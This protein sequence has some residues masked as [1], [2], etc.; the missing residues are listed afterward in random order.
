MLSEPDTRILEK[1]PQEKG[2]AFLAW[3]AELDLEHQKFDSP[4]GKG[5]LA[6]TTG[7]ASWLD[8]FEDDY[9]PGEALAED[10]LNW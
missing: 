2:A 3:M 7:I 10:L 4:Y 9:A 6:D 8:Y 5:P 1:L